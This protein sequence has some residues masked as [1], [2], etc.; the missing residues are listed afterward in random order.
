MREQD[1]ERIEGKR[2]CCCPSEDPFECVKRRYPSEEI[3]HEIEVGIKGPCECACH[4]EYWEDM[5]EY[6][7]PD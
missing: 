6:G 7:E 2:T 5:E 3:V 4:N 1:V